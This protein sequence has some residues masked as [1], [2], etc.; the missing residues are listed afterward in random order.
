M[1]GVVECAAHARHVAGDSRG[2][3]VVGEEHRLDLMA[4]VRGKRFLVPLDRG[5]FTPLGIEHEDVESQ[6]LR[7][8]DPEMAEHAEAGGE[9][10]VAWRERVRE[11]RLPRAGAAGGEDERL[12]RPGLEDLLQIFECGSRK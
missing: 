1:T 6:P 5:T 11:R 10:L 12:S 7:H 8:V 4:L 2:G 9:H 3:L